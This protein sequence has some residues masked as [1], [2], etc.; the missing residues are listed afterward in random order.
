VSGESVGN[1]PESVP[2]LSYAERVRKELKTRCAH[3]KTKMAHMPLPQPGDEANPFPTAIW[4]CGRTCVALGADGS[5][6]HPSTCD[7]PGRSCYEAP[8]GR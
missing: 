4:W 6:A 1:E 7:A 5:A 3:L 2:T 8:P